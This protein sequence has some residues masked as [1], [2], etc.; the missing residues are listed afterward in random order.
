MEQLVQKEQETKKLE[1]KQR[2][3]ENRK[4]KFLEVLATNGGN[5]SN[6]IN[7]S[8]LGRRMAYKQFA[9][10]STFADKWIEALDASN[11][12]L[13]TEARRRG[14]EGVEEPVF[15]NGKEVAKVRKYSDTLLIFMI[16]Q[17]EAQKKWRQRIIQTGNLALS[18]LQTRGSDIGLTADQ[19]EDLQLAMTEKFTSVP[20][21]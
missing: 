12:E 19:I 20:L 17:S 16:K 3:I 10:D 4:K 18:V 6:A 8:K 11:D 15:H 9:D 2:A 1:P 7:V 13:L 14:K 21:V 5:V